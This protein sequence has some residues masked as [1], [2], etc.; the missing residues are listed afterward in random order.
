LLA[1]VDI[2]DN[3]HSM[4]GYTK[5]FGSIVL[6]TIWREPN[7]VRIVWITM[8]ALADKR[9][10]VEGSVPGLA[11]LCRVSVD[12][13]REALAKL[14]APDPDSRTKAEG[15]RRILEVEG[16]WQ[17]VNHAKYRAKLNQD[18]RT[19]YLRIKKQESRV[20]KRREL[21]TPSTQP[22]AAPEAKA[23][24]GTLSGKPDDSYHKDSRAVL[25]ILNEA[26]GS[27]YREVD[28][29]LALISARLREPD[30]D[31][32]GV[33]LMI[34]RQCKLWK[35]TEW[36]PYLRPETLFAKKKFDSYY[37]NREKPTD[38]TDSRGRQGGPDRNA[39]TRHNHSE[40]A[41]GAARRVARDR[42]AMERK[43][44]GAGNV[45]PGNLPTQ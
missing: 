18:E 22:E 9:G 20:N 31:L 34:A 35:G 45:E 26:S 10:I 16:G 8:L 29:N 17:L 12:E 11:D 5:L 19:E 27:H 14:K 24:T 39:G 2:V 15:G 7:H 25:Y 38:E 6:S 3:M 42:Q 37:G 43:M 36:E 33:R 44:A 4:T 30:V 32:V 23:G 40:Y 28:S 21:S 1:S 41:A 13:C